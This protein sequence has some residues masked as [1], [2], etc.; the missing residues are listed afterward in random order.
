MVLA[1]VPLLA[2]AAGAPVRVELPRQLVLE[3]LSAVELAGSSAVPWEGHG[4]PPLWPVSRRVPRAFRLFLPPGVAVDSLRVEVQAEGLQP[5]RK[6][7]QAIPVQVNLLPLRLVQ[8]TPEGAVWEGDLLVFLDPARAE[9][10]EF[11][12]SLTV[13][14]TPR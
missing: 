12:G 13:T 6:E 5:G 1:L 14:V 10:G 11:Q 3:P 7:G 2:L 4:A 9:A 8:E